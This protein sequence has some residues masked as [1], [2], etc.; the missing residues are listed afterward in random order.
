M[1]F[2]V[3]WNFK[4][5]CGF[6]TKFWVEKCQHGWH[7]L[8]R[9][10]LV[11]L[12]YVSLPVL[13][14]EL[15]VMICF[16]F[17]CTFLHFVNIWVLS[18]YIKVIKHI[19]I[20]LLVCSNMKCPPK[21]I[22]AKTRRRNTMDSLYFTELVERSEN[23]TQQESGE[24]M[25]TCKSWK[26]AVLQQKFVIENGWGR[27]AQLTECVFTDEKITRFFKIEISAWWEMTVDLA[28]ISV[29]Y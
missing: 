7:E 22:Q 12:R 4:H 28:V 10:C 15:T 26:V 24:C 11:S 13:F 16:V 19:I 27:V 5:V 20:L 6:Q 8:L 9:F 23:T 17:C 1:K 29:F 18:F 21:L 25:C 14:T 3:V 2:F